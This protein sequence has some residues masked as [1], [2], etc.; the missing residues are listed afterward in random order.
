MKNLLTLAAVLEAA[1][2]F[3]LLFAPALVGQLLLGEVLIGVAEPVAR[4]LG[5]ALI[6][7][8]VACWPGLTAPCAM[9]TYSTSVTLYLAHLGVTGRYSGAFLWPAVIAHLILTALLAREASRTRQ[10]S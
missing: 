7:L 1:T 6:G 2:G 9:L 5:I 3:A 4:V 8:G 10:A